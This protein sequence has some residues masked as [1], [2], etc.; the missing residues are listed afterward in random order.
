MTESKGRC[1]QQIGGYMSK[2]LIFLADGFEEIEGL[3]VVDLLRRAQID[4]TTVS[5]TDRA[6]VTG[7][8]GI[9]LD[10]DTTLSAVDFAKADMIVLPGGMPGTKNLEACKPLMEQVDKYASSGKKI[11]AICAAPTVFGHRGLL[12]GK[13]ACCYPG[14]EG[15]LTGAK[16]SYDEVSVDGNVITSRGL[17]TAI[18]FAL[19]IIEA[20]LGKAE[21]DRIGK[22][23][24]YGA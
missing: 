19:A 10:T 18:P 4:I 6:K 13:K 17:G 1:L 24:V 16:V 8:H 3:T 22:A 2:V 23:I 21:A 12:K 20:F 9:A 14:M 7:A 5:I 15:D 11:A